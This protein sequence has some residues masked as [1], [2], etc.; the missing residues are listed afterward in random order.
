MTRRTGICLFGGAFDPPHQTHRRIAER[1]RQALGVD[2]LVVLPSGD[3]PHKDA[4]SM[5]PSAHRIAM[6]RH[7]FEGLDGVTVDPRETERRGPSYTVDTVR[8][9][10]DEVGDVPIYWLIGSDNLPGLPTWHDH[11]GLL[12]AATVVTFPR[13]GH[14]MGPEVLEGLALTADERR[15]LLAHRLDFPADS[16]NATAVRSS[17]RRGRRPRALRPAVAHYVRAHDLYR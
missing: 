17:L 13:R 8:E 3:H 15:V 7:N 16:V 10:R 14:P 1:A 6:C 11:H 5:A 4:S 12:A 2:R 9:F